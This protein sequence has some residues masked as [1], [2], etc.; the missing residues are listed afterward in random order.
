MGE[1]ALELEVGAA[2]GGLGIDLEMARQIH[3]REQEV[4][5]L[6]RQRLRRTLGNLRLD[7]GEFLPDLLQ[8]RADIVPVEANFAGFLL[9]LQARESAGR[10]SGTPSSAPDLAS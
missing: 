5:H 7:L 3:R 4:A 8:D 2:Q 10:A 6:A 1:A 9:Q